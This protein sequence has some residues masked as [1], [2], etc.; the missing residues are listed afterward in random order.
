MK[1]VKKQGFTLIELLVVVLI[2]GILAAVAVPQ[3]QV[4]VAKSR[5]ATIKNLT[6]SIK[7]AQEIYYLANG[8]YVTKVM[9]LDIDFPSGGELNEEGNSYTYSWG[10]CTTTTNVAYCENTQVN[11]AYQIYL[12]HS[13]RPTR[14]NCMVND[15]TDT[16]AH[17]VCKNETNRK[18]PTWSNTEASS[19]RYNT[20]ED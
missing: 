2:I 5:F 6:H 1:N 9:E 11:L 4:A 19:Y 8:H 16:V 3:Y 15:N 14:R 12:T 10:K 18:D 20:D 17:K 13:I 7:N